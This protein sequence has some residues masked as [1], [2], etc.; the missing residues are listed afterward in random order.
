MTKDAAQRSKWTFDDVVKYR[1][2]NATFHG[3]ALAP[4]IIF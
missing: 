2:Q 4:M 1:F 3:T